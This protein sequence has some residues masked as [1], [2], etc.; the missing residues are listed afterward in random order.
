R[1]GQVPLITGDEGLVH[2]RALL[3]HR[4]ARRLPVLLRIG[5]DDRTT[6][7]GLGLPAAR[8]GPALAHRGGL[9]LLRHPGN[10]GVLLLSTKHDPSLTG[11]AGGGV[12]GSWQTGGVRVV[13]APHHFG[14]LLT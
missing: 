6:T 7:T 8:R 10:L 1:G 11:P 4:G 13:L 3:A 2:L 9:D 5:G 14:H 12:H